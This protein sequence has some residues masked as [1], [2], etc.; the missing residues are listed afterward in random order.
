M[1]LLGQQLTFCHLL[2]TLHLWPHILSTYIERYARVCT[3]TYAYTHKP[4]SNLALMI[5]YLSEWMRKL[6][7]NAWSLNCLSIIISIIGRMKRNQ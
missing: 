3:H 5:A 4:T 7:H 2:Y 1:S 6:Q